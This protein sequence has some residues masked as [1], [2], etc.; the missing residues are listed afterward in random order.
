MTAL[1]LMLL[2]VPTAHAQVQRTALV[3]AN[4][5]VYLDI[6]RLAELGVLQNV[7]LGQQPYS[8]REIARIVDAA[9]KRLAESVTGSSPWIADD[10]RELADRL[11]DR[12]ASRF[13]GEDEEVGTFTPM[14]RWVDAADL[15]FTATDAARRGF[16]A[17]HTSSIEATIDPLADRRLGQPARDGRTTALT[18]SHRLEVGDWMALQLAERLESYKQADTI[19][20]TVRA[21]VLLASLRLR[22]RNAALTV[23][24]QQFTWSQEP[25]DGL[26]LASD[27]PALDQVSLASDTPFRLP[28]LLNRIGAVQ[29]TLLYADLGPSVSR[30]HSRLLAYKVSVRPSDA[31]ELGGEFMNH[32]GGT[33]G[34]PSP[35]GDR[36]VDFLPFIDIFRKHNY[37]D[38]T[39]ALDVDSDKLLGL[40]GRFRLGWLAGITLGGEILLDDFDVHRLRYL[41]TEEGSQSAFILVPRLGTVNLSMVLSAKHMG[42]N[43]YSHTAL[44]DGI[45]TRG[46]LLGDELGPDAKNFGATLRYIPSPQ[47]RVELE[48]RNVAY[49]NATYLG[50]YTDPAQTDFQVRKASSTPNELR[51]IGMATLVLQPVDGLALN[52]RAGGERI[53]N[54]D[55]NGGRRRDYVF[56]ASVRIVR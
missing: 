26:F 24:R 20:A 52:L 32:F 11:V 51:D 4:D 1:G 53:R 37:A 49:S 27:A 54:A 21:D 18:L 6:A 22:F 35:F 40:D 28:W 7:V 19:A 23:G 2:T 48:G 13:A 12:I 33:G 14:I 46:R 55:F 43:T 17:P 38:T 8:R 9:Q 3:Q 47:L 15:T 45:T 30:S 39:R 31:V 16:P 34:R 56:E 41:F 5:P 42:P 25:G 50:F 36:L 10:A 29:G 44:L